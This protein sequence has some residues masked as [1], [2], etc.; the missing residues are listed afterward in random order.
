[1]N[2][3]KKGD[4]NQP[5]SAL[6]Y[7][8]IALAGFV[9][10]IGF[11]LFYV[12]QVPKLVQ[13][14][15]EGKIF[16]LLLIPWA[17][18][19]AA[20]L[21]G[22]MKSYATL[23]SKHL[24]SFLELGGPV[25]LFALV[26]VGGFKLVPPPPEMFDLTV[27]AYDE[28]NEM[29]RSGIISID[30]GSDRRPAP[31]GTNGEANIKQVRKELMGT[32]VKVW[33]QVEGYETTPLERKLEGQVLEVNLVKEHPITVLMGSLSPTPPKPESVKI[34]VDGQ[35]A[36][37]SPDKYGRFELSVSGKAGERIRMKVFSNEKLVYDD[38]QYL[39]GPVTLALR[40][41]H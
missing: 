9:F 33:P 5:M 16:Y 10:A 14:G 27:R 2:A 35:K 25:V 20:F 26:M 13:S 7:A 28:H 17:L 11:T 8:M 41:T 30:F 19:C 34:L 24:G 3:V 18:S 31:I 4:P 39:P 22:T 23:T 6:A 32:T 40:K 37:A 38:Y 15:I 12:Y 21:F 36:E 29:I 1:M